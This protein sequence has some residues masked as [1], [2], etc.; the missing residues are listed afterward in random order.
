MRHFTPFILAVCS[1]AAAA[2]AQ[3][4]AAKTFD[5]YVIDVEGGD[6][7]LFVAPS[8]ESLLMD[9]GSGGPDSRD[10]NR[11]LDAVKDAGLTHL[12]NLLTTHWHGDHFGGMAELAS[13]I[14]IRNFIDHGPNT[15]N[16]NVRA[17]QFL[18]DTYPSLY[19]KAKH[20][21]VKAGDR[22][23]VAGLDWRVVTAAGGVIRTPLAGGGH[24]NPEC[25]SFQPRD[26]DDDGGVEN[27]NSVGSV[28][29]FGKFRIV[30][31]GDLTWNKEFELMCPNNP[32]GTTDVFV[33]SN[34]SLVVSNTP[35]LVH[36]LRPRVIIMNNGIRKGGRPETMMTF[37]SSPGLENLWELHF[38][39]LSGQEYSVPGLFIA[40]PLDDP[41][42]TMPIAP[43]P[44]P[45]DEY[46]ARE[47]RSPPPPTHNGKAYWIKV[48]AQSDGS[49]TVTNQRNRFTKTYLARSRQ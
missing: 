37:Y 30:H 18:H 48:S 33:V 8:G 12:D 26:K 25:A 21:V 44:P 47:P 32:I 15:Q 46:L 17:E 49:F 9:T 6:A 41:M 19:A 14:E 27:P 23:P 13:R 1:F 5:I 42:T 2:G 40:N 16:P 28:V 43:M 39:L 29:A 22:I 20:T 7:T 11:I 35:V 38:S 3:A 45:A 31:L 24:P 34:H 4:Q 36:A 10:V